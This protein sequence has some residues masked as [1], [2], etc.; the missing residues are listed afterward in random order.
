[1]SAFFVFLSV[2]ALSG[3]ALWAVL[4]SA[5]YVPL[6][7]AGVGVIVSNLLRALRWLTLFQGRPEVRYRFVFSSLVIGYLADNVMPIRVGEL[8]RMYVLEELTGVPFGEAAG[9]VVVERVV[10]AFVVLTGLAALLVIVPVRKAIRIGVPFAVGGLVA[11]TVVL[12]LMAWR[13]QP[14]LRL[15]RRLTRRLPE[16]ARHRL[17]HGTARFIE[18]LA[19]FREGRLA[20]QVLVLSAVIWAV[21]GAVVGVAALGLGL[22]MPGLSS[23]FLSTLLAASFAIPAG[24]GGIGTY[25]YFGQVA[26]GP[27]GV[28]GSVAAGLVLMLHGLSYA[29]TVLLGVAALSLE[30]LSLRSLAGRKRRVKDEGVTR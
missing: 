20:V 12:L 25:E 9:T 17:T 2:R 10:E 7:L 8:V 27:L 21:D 26:L 11:A 4:R 19:L 23:L 5:N 18:G 16:K 1:M 24:P 28:H 14:M 22:R 13:P 3:H 6:A 15:V 30:G 29:V